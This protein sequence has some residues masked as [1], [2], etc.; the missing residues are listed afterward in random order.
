[1]QRR[2]SWRSLEQAAM[3]SLAELAFEEAL[4]IFLIVLHDVDFQGCHDSQPFIVH[5]FTHYYPSLA[6]IKLRCR[7]VAD[8]TETG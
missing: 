4:T 6:S 7:T 1:M 5:H 2:W 3:P 8:D